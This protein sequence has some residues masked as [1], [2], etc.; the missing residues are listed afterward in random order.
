M[1]VS[2][3]VQPL[4]C[5]NLVGRLVCATATGKMTATDSGHCVYIT[6]LS[7]IYVGPWAQQVFVTT[8]R[9]L[10][11]LHVLPD[12][13]DICGTAPLLLTCAVLPDPIDMCCDARPH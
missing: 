12:P 9:A 13:I 8:A 7:G 4:P 1:T 11:S 5:R 6:D 3:C 10:Q 2:V